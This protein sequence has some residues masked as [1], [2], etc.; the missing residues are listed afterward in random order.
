MNEIEAKV[1][2]MYAE[3]VKNPSRSKFVPPDPSV[4][5]T[6]HV[7]RND[8]LSSGVCSSGN[9]ESYIDLSTTVL[10]GTTASST[11]KSL[12]DCYLSLPAI[13]FC[14]HLLGFF[15]LTLEPC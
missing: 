6:M 9:L 15:V 11:P 2:A 12:P 3:V 10:P 13:L 7:G 1:M 14:Y 5:G 4:V 8:S